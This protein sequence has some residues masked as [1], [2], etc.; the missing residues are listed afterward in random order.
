[1]CERFVILCVIGFEKEENKI[2]VRFS[3][4]IQ[5]ELIDFSLRCGE[6]LGRASKNNNKKMQLNMIGGKGFFVWKRTN[7]INKSLAFFERLH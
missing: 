1:M 7:E 6:A 2:L 4:E 3:A 5:Y